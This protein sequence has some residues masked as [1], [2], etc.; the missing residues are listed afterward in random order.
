M[1]WAFYHEPLL[2]EQAVAQEFTEPTDWLPVHAISSENVAETLLGSPSAA[3]FMPEK[4]NGDA[5]TG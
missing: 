1:V 3:N 5:P 2:A 4:T